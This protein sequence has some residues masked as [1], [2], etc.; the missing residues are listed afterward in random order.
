MRR[1][2]SDVHVT[3]AR[4]L[5][6]ASPSLPSHSRLDSEVSR[7]HIRIAKP[8]GSVPGRNTGKCGNRR[9]QG[10]PIWRN[11]GSLNYS[12]GIQISSQVSLLPDTVTSAKGAQEE[13][14]LSAPLSWTRC[15]IQQPISGS[16]VSVSRLTPFPKIQ[17]HCYVMPYDTFLSARKANPRSGPSSMYH[18]WYVVKG[19]NSTGLQLVIGLNSSGKLGGHG[20][21]SQAQDVG[22]FFL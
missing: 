11:H 9:R 14:D 21:F 1:S 22:R 19:P 16:R 3:T 8:V 7:R 15:C 4:N 10:H 6:T 2:Y 20:R 12:A 17:S 5:L 13:T 18:M